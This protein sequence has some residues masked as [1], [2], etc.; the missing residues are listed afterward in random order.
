MVNEWVKTTPWHTVGDLF[1]RLDAFKA[2]RHL[3]RVVL[4]GGR[5]AEHMNNYRPLGTAK[6]VKG[7]TDYFLL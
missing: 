2:L 4:D 5:I 6:K 1:L 7:D 3:D